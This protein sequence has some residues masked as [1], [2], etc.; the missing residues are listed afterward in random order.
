MPIAAIETRYGG[1]RFRSRLEARW[2]VFFDHLGIR[3]TYEPEGYHTDG[4]DYLPDFWLP[5][6]RTWIEV[7]AEQPSRNEVRRM[8]A[9]ASDQWVAK[10]RF[11]VLFD[12]PRQIET[13]LPCRVWGSTQTNTGT[14][15]ARRWMPVNASK[16]ATGLVAARSARFEHGE[17][18]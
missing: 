16:V 4:G 11:R 10:N 7:K 1:C 14:F 13:G 18:G 6:E 9:F 17:R 12:I 5:R 2:A 3:W 15:M 8:A